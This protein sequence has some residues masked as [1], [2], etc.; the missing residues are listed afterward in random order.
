MRGE[1]RRCAWDNGRSNGPA[2]GAEQASSE[3]RNEAADGV[4]QAGPANLY[5]SRK[6]H[7][8]TFPTRAE[9]IGSYR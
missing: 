3:F 4:E 6:S 7:A 2:R 9:Y 1:E 8:K 5:D